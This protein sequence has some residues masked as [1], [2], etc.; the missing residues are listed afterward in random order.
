MPDRVRKG[1]NTMTHYDYIVV[2]GGMTASAATAGIRRHDK[3]GT[4]GIF[5]AERYP[6]YSRPPLS[7]K[8][9]TDERVE[10][11]WMKPDVL[12]LHA[13][14]HLTTTI[15]S[16]DPG[17]HT[18][19]DQ[20]GN[21]YHFGKLL[22]ATGGS[23]KTLPFPDIPIIYFRTL[24]DYFHLYQLAQTRDRFLVIGGGFIGTEI[25][26]ALNLQ[27]KS[28]TVI[29]PEAHLVDRLFPT[30]LKQHIDQFYRDKGV[31]L[32]NSSVLAQ[33]EQDAQGILVRD[34]NGR[35]T[36]VDAVVAGIGLRPN[37]DLA[38]A[39]HLS[40]GDGIAVNEY[41]QTSD[42]NIYAAGDVASF[43][44]PYPGQKSRV[45]H[46]DNALS[47]G[48]AAG[49][50]M[51]GAHRAYSHLPFFYSDMFSMG[52]EAI[53]LLDASLEIFSDWVTFGEEGVLYYLKDRKVVGVLNWNVWDQIP[54]AREIIVAQKIYGDPSALAGTIHN[55]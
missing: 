27:G 25:A 26:A 43:P 28:V 31:D 6:I 23:P 49:A 40:V 51:A 37:T 53:G 13:D 44:Y 55:R 34:G 9:W 50:N 38:E 7:K 18:V 11:L 32:W 10:S 36:H 21:L 39:A 48:K 47:Q 29:Y 30:D 41:L 8:L 45:E 2:G 3:S 46:E 5:S 4:I 20:Y 42:S 24:E 19:S 33:L 52:Y 22:L 15:H 17:N 35:T 54:Q 12:T 14:E 1:R 16:V